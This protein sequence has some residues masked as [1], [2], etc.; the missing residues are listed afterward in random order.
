MHKG[1]KITRAQVQTNPEEILSKKVHVAKNDHENGGE[2][3]LHVC[4]NSFT[5]GITNP[6]ISTD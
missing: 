3:Y 2:L 6:Q 1:P 4:E 5:K